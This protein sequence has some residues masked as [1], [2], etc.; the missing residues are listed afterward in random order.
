MSELDMV[1][2]AVDDFREI[3]GLIRG[4]EEIGK[5]LR[6][7]SREMPTILSES[8][9]LSAVSLC[10]AKAGQD[11]YDQLLS[12]LAKTGKEG[13]MASVEEVNGTK[14]GYA[15]YLYLLLK[16]ARRLGVVGGVDEKK[17][18]E[19][20]ERLSENLGRLAIL[21]RLLYPFLAQIK[22]LCEATLKAE[23]E[24]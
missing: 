6:S 9:L 2:S 23:Q 15:I 18:L 12:L 8:G 13:S 1:K 21:E 24:E 11:V 14:M 3:Y 4:F 5:S 20:I 10:Y 7:R 22:R 19:S 16:G 17:P